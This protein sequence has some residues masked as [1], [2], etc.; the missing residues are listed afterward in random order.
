[1]AALRRFEYSIQKLLFWSRYLCLHAILHLLSKF[2]TTR[3]KLR[4]N[5]EENFLYVDR[6]P[7]WIC[8]LSIFLSNDHPRNRNSHRPTKV[9]RNRMIHDWD[10]EIKLFSKWRTSAILNFRKLRIKSSHLC[11]HVFLHLRSKFSSN[12]P[13]WR[14]DIAKMIF[15]MTF[16]RHLEFAKFDFSGQKSIFGMEICICVPNL[17]EKSDNSRL[18]C[19]DKKYFQNAAVRHLEFSKIAVLVTWPISAYDSLYMIQISH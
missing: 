4:R 2:R 16:V 5:I 11:L 15:N 6:Q 3:P 1:M 12:R 17:M 18:R 14:W 19:G 13:I 7:S 8:K 10:M 9:D